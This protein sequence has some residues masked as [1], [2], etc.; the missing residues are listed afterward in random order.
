MIEKEK[1]KNK[2][3]N[4]K[5]TEGTPL[6]CTT[7]RDM[8]VLEKEE[9]DQLREASS[10]PSASSNDDMSPHVASTASSRASPSRACPSCTCT[11]ALD[12]VV[13]KQTENTTNPINA[14]KINL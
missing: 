5:T 6:S 2:T 8:L 9:A 12:S 10:L 1:K 14:L 11:G 7:P 13:E 4:I 3:K